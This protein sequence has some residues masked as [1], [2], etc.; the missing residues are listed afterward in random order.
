MSSPH[1][2]ATLP[3]DAQPG[4]VTDVGRVVLPRR[5]IKPGDEGPWDP[6]SPA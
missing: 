6:R 2:A 4:A 5:R 3:G 1:D